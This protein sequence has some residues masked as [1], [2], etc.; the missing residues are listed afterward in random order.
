MKKILCLFTI[1][2]VFINASF[3]FEQK[4]FL[5][6]VQK[7]AAGFSLKQ[8]EYYVKSLN[9]TETEREQAFKKL[10]ANY[11]NYYA[12][13][14]R[15]YN[16]NVGIPFEKEYIKEHKDEYIMYGLGFNIPEGI[17]E[18]EE[19]YTMLLNT[20]AIPEHWAE[21]LILQQKYIDRNRK[22]CTNYFFRRS[23][24]CEGGTMT[25]SQMEQAIVDL[26]KVE[27]KSKVI[28]SIKPQ[29]YD[30]IPYTS[31]EL[32]DTY[33]M[34]N[35]LKPIFNWNKNQLGK[36][37]KKSQKSF[38]HFIKKHKDSKYWDVVNEYYKK[39]KQNDFIYSAYINAWLI[40]E[41]ESMK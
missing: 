4:D 16:K 40:D 3:G 22:T 6:Y 41:L 1:L 37:D 25:I 15:D 10:Y 28:E 9:Q 17:W 20:P 38:E 18:L 7:R 5:S 2:L 8:E 21:W 36:L 12:S 39:L 33:L 24:I 31:R 32:I 19:D 13:I 35:D 23:S 27:Q 34:G 14:V 30:F 29:N 26:D 11:I